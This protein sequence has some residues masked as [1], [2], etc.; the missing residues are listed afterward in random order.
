MRGLGMVFLT[1]QTL[2]RDVRTPQVEN[3]ALRQCPSLSNSDKVGAG[4]M[5]AAVNPDRGLVHAGAGKA[6]Q[7]RWSRGCRRAD[8]SFWSSLWLQ[9]WPLAPRKKKKSSLTRSALSRPRPES[10][11]DLSARARQPRLNGPAP[12]LGR[13][14]ACAT[15]LNPSHR[16]QTVAPCLWASAALSLIRPFGRH[17]KGQQIC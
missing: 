8:V 15:W 11:S 13:L 4:R 3:L 2:S 14:L 1:G 9:P 5:R 10:T 7:E 6:P 12:C 16:N 17:D